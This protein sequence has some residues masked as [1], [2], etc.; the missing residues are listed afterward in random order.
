MQLFQGRLYCT[1]WD[2]GPTFH[3]HDEAASEA[4]IDLEISSLVLGWGVGVEVMGL[5]SLL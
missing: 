3:V 5:V 4:P 1:V 2:K